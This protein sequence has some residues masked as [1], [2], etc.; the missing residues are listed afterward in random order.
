MKYCYLLGK[1]GYVFG[2]IGLY[3]C[4]FVCGIHYSKLL[5]QIRMKLYEGVLCSTGKKLLNFDGDLG[6]LR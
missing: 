4:L 5:K 1:R 3:V 2:S 6:T